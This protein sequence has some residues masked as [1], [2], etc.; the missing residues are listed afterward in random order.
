[1]TFS[2]IALQ[3]NDF[4]LKL[5]IPPK[6]KKMA[7]VPSKIQLSNPGPPWPSCS[8]VGLKVVNV[9]WNGENDGY[10]L[11]LLFPQCFEMTSIPRALR[12]CFFVVK[13]SEYT[14]NPLPHMPILGSSNLAA[15]E[16]MMSKIRING[17]QLLLSRKHCWKRRK[18]LITNNF[19]FSHNVF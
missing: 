7:M 15:N 1:M 19:F 6:K 13:G 14:L 4:I 12:V 18:F 10:Q 8:L 9:V 2:W 16:N 11:F 3:Y 5:S 17:V